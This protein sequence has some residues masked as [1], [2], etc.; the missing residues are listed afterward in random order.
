MKALQIIIF[1]LIVA[2]FVCGNDNVSN[3]ISGFRNLTTIT[4]KLP[5]SEQSEIY[6]KSM[7]SKK[8]LLELAETNKNITVIL[9]QE[10]L[11]TPLPKKSRY[12]DFLYVCEL[13]DILGKQNRNLLLSCTDK[14]LDSTNWSRMATCRLLSE[15]L[16]LRRLYATNSN[17]N[18]ELLRDVFLKAANDKRMNVK[19]VAIRGLIGVDPVL[20]EAAG[21]YPVE[22]IDQKNGEIIAK[23]II[24]NAEDDSTKIR[25]YKK[26]YKANLAKTEY[27]NY[28]KE[29]MSN[30]NV[31]LFARKELAEKLLS[32]KGIDKKE[33]DKLRSEC[34]NLLEKSQREAKAANYDA[35]SKEKQEAIKQGMLEAMR[36]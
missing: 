15:I 13:T 3:L 32:I 20:A 23:Q 14:I 29:E 12:G 30:T 8:E 35:E 21:E 17:F 11:N 24:E 6:E 5:I 25:F 16:R 27:I 22:P 4:R 18:E 19:S 28:L 36:Y 26:L 31:H 34:K 10:L 7:I 2:T 33:V 9:G 1:S